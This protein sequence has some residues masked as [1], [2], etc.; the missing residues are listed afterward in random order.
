MLSKISNAVKNFKCC[1][2]LQILSKI[3]KLFKKKLFFSYNVA[4]DQLM[5]VT[6]NEPVLER[7]WIT[8][9]LNKPDMAVLHG[10][11]GLDFNYEHHYVFHSFLC[12]SAA[13]MSASYRLLYSAVLLNIFMK[14]F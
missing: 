9:P 11:T 8:D 7:H 5:T 12:S 2:K 3:E 14:F 1:Q 13:K 10:Q 6:T 4:T